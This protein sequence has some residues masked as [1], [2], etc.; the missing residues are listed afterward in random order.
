MSSPLKFSLWVMLGPQVPE[1]PIPIC[2]L[3]F[4][5]SSPEVNGL[6]CV[7]VLVCKLKVF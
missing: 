5:G 4:I 2:V 1:I 3:V 6:F 7:G